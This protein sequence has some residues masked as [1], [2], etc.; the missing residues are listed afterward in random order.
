MEFQHRRAMTPSGSHPSG[1]LVAE[2]KGDHRTGHLLST[3]ER[4]DSSKEWRNYAAEASEDA[5]GVGIK[6][7][8]QTHFER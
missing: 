4:R 3:G 8:K 5:G 7:Q 2:I 1:T 6:I